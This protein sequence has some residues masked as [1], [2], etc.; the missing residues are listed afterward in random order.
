MS[1]ERETD[2]LRQR[3]ENFE[4]LEALGVASYPHDYPVTDTVTTLVE[5]HGDT[6]GETLDQQQVHTST[7]SSSCSTLVTTSARK[8]GCSGPAPTS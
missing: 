7:A 8:D 6:D 4:A 3:R 1:H 5:T 2:Q